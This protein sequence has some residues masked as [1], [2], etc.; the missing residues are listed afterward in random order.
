MRPPLLDLGFVTDGTHWIIAQHCDAIR[1]IIS[2]EEKFPKHSTYVS[3]S[4]D[5][6]GDGLVVK[7]D[8]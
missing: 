1:D 5:L 8:Y 6:V 3:V 7:Y 4:R 2:H